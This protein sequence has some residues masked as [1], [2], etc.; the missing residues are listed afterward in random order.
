MD[1]DGERLAHAR[2][3]IEDAVIMACVKP[4][5]EESS[6]VHNRARHEDPEVLLFYSSSNLKE[7]FSRTR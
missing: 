5:V 4:G 6:R 7:M 2:F 1:D 3:T